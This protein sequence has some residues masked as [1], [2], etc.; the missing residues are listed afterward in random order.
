MGTTQ[1]QAWQAIGAAKNI[2]RWITVQP[3]NDSEKAR[4]MIADFV[5]MARLLNHKAVREGRG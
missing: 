2:K 1:Q 5:H 4:L 3:A